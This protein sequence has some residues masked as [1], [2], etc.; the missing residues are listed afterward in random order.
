MERLI[1]VEILKDACCCCLNVQDQMT[2]VD[3]ELKGIFS[4]LI[5][6]KVSQN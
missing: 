5:N 1:A 4:E 3:R 2:V 6:E